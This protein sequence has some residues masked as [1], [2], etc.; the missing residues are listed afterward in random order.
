MFG[1]NDDEDNQNK[2]EQLEDK[3]EKLEDK[4]ANV[5]S[6]LEIKYMKMSKNVKMTLEQDM[7]G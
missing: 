6:I 1:Y 4:I 7:D 3:V 2:I 5:Y